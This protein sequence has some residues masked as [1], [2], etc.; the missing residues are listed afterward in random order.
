M[1]RPVPLAALGLSALN[2]S[3]YPVGAVSRS[4]GA[5]RDLTFSHGS[6]DGRSMACSLGG[7]AATL[8]CFGL[9]VKAH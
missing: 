4:L 3:P 1:G 9:P 5:G 6:F 2:K 7:S 8:L